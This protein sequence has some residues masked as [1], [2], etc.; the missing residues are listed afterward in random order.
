VVKELKDFARA[1]KGAAVDQREKEE[2]R[3]AI[4]QLSEI[5]DQLNQDLKE[6]RR[7]D[8]MAQEIQRLWQQFLQ[9]FTRLAVQ[10]NYRPVLQDLDRFHLN[11]QQEQRAAGALPRLRARLVSGVRRRSAA[12]GGKAKATRRAPT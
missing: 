9:L 2:I 4:R 10:S 11:E 5:K 12:Y 1:V 7:Y 8:V 6:R 3:E